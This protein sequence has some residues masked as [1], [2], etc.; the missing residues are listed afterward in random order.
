MVSSI[1]VENIQWQLDLNIQMMFSVPKTHFYCAF[2]LRVN[3][4]ITHSSKR[5]FNKPFQLFRSVFSYKKKTKVFTYHKEKKN[6]IKNI[7]LNVKSLLH[8][9]KTQYTFDPLDFHSLSFF[10][11]VTLK[12]SV[13]LLICLSSVFW[14]R[15]KL[16][17]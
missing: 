12:T 15:S 14:R 16:M 10:S 2:K 1:C 4:V 7:H 5:A 13:M 9:K 6:W 17:F 8:K 11:F 3:P